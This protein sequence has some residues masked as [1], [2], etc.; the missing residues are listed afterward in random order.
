MGL[1]K[2]RMMNDSGLAGFPEQN[3]M[4][5]PQQR[6]LL[7]CRAT[8]LYLFYFAGNDKRCQSRATR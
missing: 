8:A 1:D 3:M 7:G 4:N 5:T 2:E 6:M